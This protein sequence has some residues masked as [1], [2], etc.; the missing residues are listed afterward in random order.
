[1][2]T[3]VVF[4]V[5]ETLWDETPLW[6]GW[7]QWLGVPPFTLYGVI[8]G[9][10][11][12]GQDHQDFLDV[13]RPGADRAALIAAKQ[14]ELPAALGIDDLYADA[15]PCL[16]AVADDGWQV[17]VGGNQPA[18]FQVLVEALDLPVDRVTSSGEL[19]VAKPDPAFFTAVAARAGV[20]PSACVHVGDRIDN[21]VVGALASGMTAV[22]LR[23]GPWGHLYADDPALRHDH[24][25]QIAGLGELPALLRS[26]R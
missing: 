20:E 18:T 14:R 11:A 21:D 9:L 5:G 16:R 22:H 25:H 24:A 2:L 19:G 13:F 10:A 26:L 7:A 1:M 6:A 8:G 23:R 12:R 17:I 15:V 4:D 3:T